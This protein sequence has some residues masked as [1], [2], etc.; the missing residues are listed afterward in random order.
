MDAVHYAAC[1][2]QTTTLP[3]IGAV[4]SLRG[5]PD[6]LSLSFEVSPV[7]DLNSHSSGTWLMVSHRSTPCLITSSESP[8]LGQLGTIEDRVGE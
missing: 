2:R 4:E 3:A 7:L 5:C 6:T 8:K 1:E